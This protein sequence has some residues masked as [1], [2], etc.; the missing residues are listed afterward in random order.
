MSTPHDTA[1]DVLDAWDRGETIWTVEMGGMGPGYEQCIVIATMEAIRA[2]V[3]DPDRLLKAPDETAL[4]DRLNQALWANAVV[5]ALR[6]SGAQAG[7]AKN[8]AYHALK[9]GWRRTLESAPQDHLVQ[10]SKRFP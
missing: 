3:D 9:S 10:A 5:S 4:N 2:F 7:A 6:L 1:R 8:L